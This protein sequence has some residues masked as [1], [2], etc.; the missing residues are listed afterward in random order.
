M[1]S[2]E[3]SKS[4]VQNQSNGNVRPLIPRTNIDASKIGRKSPPRA[5]SG[6]QRVPCENDDDPGPSAA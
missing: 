6:Q 4:P 1:T 3:R 5:T 2:D